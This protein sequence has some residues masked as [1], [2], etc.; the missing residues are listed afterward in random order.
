MRGPSAA[1]LLLLAVALGAG[2]PA[3]GTAGAQAGDAAR[4]RE[5]FAAKRCSRCHA[6]RAERGVGPALEE[7]RRHQGAYELAGR[8]WNHAPAMFTVLTQ[9]GLEWPTI[10]AAEMANLMAYLQADPARDPAPDARKGQLVLVSKGCLKCHSWKREG[11]RVGP[12]LAERQSSYAPAATWAAA[13]WRHTPRM[14]AK[15]IE[16]GVLYPRFTGDEMGNLLA[17]LRSAAK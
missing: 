13:M 10:G 3:P 16:L 17:F 12:D 9:E 11:G 14:A 6:P 15:A 1:V 5:V 2:T 7:L 4:G 8:L